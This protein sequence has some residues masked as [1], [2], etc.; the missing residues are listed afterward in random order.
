MHAPYLFCID[1]VEYIAY[2]RCEGAD[3][4]ITSI[5]RL[6]AFNAIANGQLLH[7]YGLPST[8]TFVDAA[9]FGIS[10]EANWGHCTEEA[11]PEEAAGSTHRTERYQSNCC[12]GPDG[13]EQQQH[14]NYR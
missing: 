11:Q 7:S 10:R 14:S 1:I 12:Q 8:S 4:S 3:C 13:S 9:H 6:L 5:S 2:A